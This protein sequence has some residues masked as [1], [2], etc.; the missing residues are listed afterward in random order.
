MY[1]IASKIMILLAFALSMAASAG[2]A[3]LAGKLEEMVARYQSRNQIQGNIL[4]K[5]NGVTLFEKS[6]GQANEEWNVSHT[7]ESKFMIASISKQFTAYAILLL[8]NEGRLSLSDSISKYISLPK[9]TP[10]SEEFWESITLYHLLTH[11]SGL[12][13]DVPNTEHLN[14]SIQQP[15]SN[16]VKLTLSESKIEGSKL[17][18]FSYSNLGYLILA[19]VIEEVSYTPYDRFIQ[20]KIFIPVRMYQSGEY[21]R[22]KMISHMSEGYFYTEAYRKQKRCCDDG[23]VLRGSHGLYSTARDLSLWQQVLIEGS[24]RMNQE[25]LDKLTSLQSVIFPNQEKSFYGFGLIQD[26]KFKTKRLWHEGHEWGFISLVSMLPELGITITV[27]SNHHDF[28]LF[29]ARSS[30]SQINDE[31]T[32]L[33]IQEAGAL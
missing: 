6:F 30:M 15:L 8:E 7:P 4:I 17:G 11:T 24:S 21:H 28:E 31:L 5:K 20:N 33:M 27:L 2:Q 1:R 23:S 13:R 9:G 10:N 14:R 32:Q 26:T 19:H 3:E 16:I 12:V 25:V 18:E 29:N 22:S